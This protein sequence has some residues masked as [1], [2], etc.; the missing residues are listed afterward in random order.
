M[1]RDSTP[2]QLASAAYRH[3]AGGCYSVFRK[4]F[5]SAAAL[6][7]WTMATQSVF[8]TAN[9]VYHEQ[10]GNDVTGGGTT[11]CVGARP[12]VP[13]ST[14]TPAQSYV[15]RFKVEYQFFTDTL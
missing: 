11:T 3:I 8:A 5:A 13:V 14:P 2:K 7:C 6:V 1:K 10:T 12:Y 9:Y 4:L 15:F